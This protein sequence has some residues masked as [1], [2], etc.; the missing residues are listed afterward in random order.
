V[1][2]DG[3]GITRQER[4]TLFGR[5]VRGRSEAKGT[6]LGLFLVEQVARAHGGRVD[7]ETEEG[8]GS[9]FTLVLP[10]QPPTSPGKPA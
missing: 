2:D 9:T 10:L 8:R 5:F 1:T 7:L 4:R 3:P 6:G